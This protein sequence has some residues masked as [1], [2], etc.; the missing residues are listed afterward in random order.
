MK[1]WLF[2]IRRSGLLMNLGA[3]ERFHIIRTHPDV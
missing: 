1:L 3:G 2:H